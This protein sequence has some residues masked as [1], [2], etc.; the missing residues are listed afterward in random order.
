MEARALATN[1]VPRLELLSGFGIV[2][3]ITDARTYGFH[4]FEIDKFEFCCFSR[5]VGE[6]GGVGPHDVGPLVTDHVLF[7]LLTT[8]STREVLDALVLP[9]W[10]QA[11][12]PRFVSWGL[13][14]ISNECWRALEHKEF[15]GRFSKSGN[16]LHCS[17]AGSDDADALALQ[18]VHEL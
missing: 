3:R 12:K 15:L 4:D 18:F 16:N 14:A 6:L 2:N 5:I 8:D 1:A 7:R 11:L 9:T 17:C 10:L 13:A